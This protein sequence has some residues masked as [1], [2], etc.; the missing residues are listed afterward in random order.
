MEGM[1][2]ANSDEFETRWRNGI[3][4]QFQHQNAQLA[5]IRERLEETC[6]AL[7][8][9]KTTAA[10]TAK[11]EEFKEGVRAAMEAERE[12]RRLR[13]DSMAKEYDTK[14]EAQTK[15]GDKLETS[16]SVLRWVG[17]VLGA[18]AIAALKFWPK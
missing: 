12:A 17:G 11:F 13:I 1:L 16:I 14:I 15:R 3:D 9:I 7:T 6:D 18:I 4:T 10:T 2:M 8:I 5:E